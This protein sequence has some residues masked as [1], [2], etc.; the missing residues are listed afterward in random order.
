VVLV[1]AAGSGVS[2]A[3]IQLARLAGAKVVATAGGPEKVEAARRLGADCVI[4]SRGAPFRESLVP[5]LKGMGKRGVDVA[6][7]HVGADT[8]AES[9]RSLARGGRLVVCGAT[10]GARVTLDLKPIFYKSLSLLGSTLGARADL[11]QLR[12]RAAAGELA[13]VI[14][15]VHPIEDL[16]SA[17]GR[18]AARRAF[19]KIVLDA[20]ATAPGGRNGD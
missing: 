10:S 7:D 6:V 3:A 13:P 9:V 4:D 11:E 16:P 20:S 19:G 12:A 1:H 18:L 14:D 17:L 8:L 5:Y 2:V 15:S